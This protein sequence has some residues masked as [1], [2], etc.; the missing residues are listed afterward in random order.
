MKERTADIIHF[1]A[2]TLIAVAF[3]FWSAHHFRYTGP[4]TVIKT[5]TDTLVVRDTLRVS[6]PVYV[7]RRI[8]DTILVPVMV[9]GGRDTVLVQVPRE[10]KVYQDSSYRAV[11]SGYMP[12]LDTIDVYRREVYVTTLERVEVPPSRWSWGIQA[13][14][15]YGGG[16]VT[17]Y[18]GLGVQFSLG[19][20]QF[21][22]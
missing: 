12:S 10:E 14:I 22:K 9:P 18:V 13:G 2:A 7:T 1:L 8:V 16:G 5:V 11:V 15:G 4:E 6:T 20:L 21:K 3:G 17:P 19:T